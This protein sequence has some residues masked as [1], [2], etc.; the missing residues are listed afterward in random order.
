MSRAM[1][2]SNN[3]VPAL[4]VFVGGA[5][6]SVIFNSFSLFARLLLVGFNGFIPS[7]TT[8]MRA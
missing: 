7:K 2:K 5:T 1:G 8:A 3:P 4:D 6:E